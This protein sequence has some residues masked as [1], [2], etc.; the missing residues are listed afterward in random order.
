MKFE[1]VL[2][3]YLWEKV[4]GPDGLASELNQIFKEELAP[5]L[6][7]LSPKTEEERILSHS[8]Y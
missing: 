5:I 2:K 7:K 8:F 4:S 1:V 6:R 3:K